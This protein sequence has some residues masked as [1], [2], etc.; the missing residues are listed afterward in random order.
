MEQSHSY[1]P[2]CLSLYLNYFVH[3]IGVIIL[4]QN[5]DTLAARW[6]TIADVAWVI[7]MLGI[8][9]LIVLFVSGKL[10][11]KYGR[12]PFVLLGM[13]TYISFFAGILLSPTSTV[14]CIFGI[15]AGI[16]NSFLDAGTYPA[17]IESYPESASTVTVLLKAFISAGQF[18]LPL[19]IGLLL[20][21]GAWYGWSFLVAAAILGINIPFML[22]MSYPSMNPVKD[23]GKGAESET[24]SAWLPKSKWYL[25]GICFVIYGY[26][27]QATF[28]L[29][30]QWLTK[31]GAAVAQMSDMAAR[32]L[33]S[34]YSVGSLACVFFTAFITKK[35]VRP[36][37]LLVVYTLIST[38]AISG[39]YYLPSATLAPILSA[40]VGFSAAGGVMQ[41]GLVMMTEMFPKG[42][43]TMTGIFYTTGSIASFT[44]PVVTGYMA[45]SGINSIMGLDAAIALAG[46]IIACIIY[47]RYNSVMKE[48]P[49]A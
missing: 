17:L 21:S 28:Y 10:S 13:V 1:R 7:S 24:A 43:G 19:F 47:I 11:D 30:S 6:G 34:Y 35:G 45:D 46:F 49:V 29:I 3:G 25:E 22:K 8:G 32:S 4:A 36:I 40:V 41:L 23:T 2:L 9:R 16:A 15:L 42:K 37:T 48:K 33:M 27:S 18:L 20:A 5:M 38:L 44:I 39:L 12:K 14:A 26:I 31:Y